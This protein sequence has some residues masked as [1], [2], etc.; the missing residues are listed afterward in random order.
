MKDCQHI[1]KL[2]YPYL[3]GELDPGQ[4]IDVE[5]HILSCQ[6]CSDLFSQE[7]RFL[8]ILK[9]GCFKEEA[10][11]SLKAKVNRLLEKEQGKKQRS[12]FPVFRNNPFRFA[13]AASLAGLLVMLFTG[14]LFDGGSEVMA[15]PPFVRA[16]VENHLQ[17]VKGKFPLEIKSNDPKIVFAWFKEKMN[18]MPDLPIIN[19]ERV[20]LLGGRITNFQ[21]DPMALVSYR[22]DNSPVTMLIIQGKAEAFVESNDHTFL[23]GRRFNFSRYKEFNT[24][25]W[26][27]DGNNFALISKFHSQNIK[28]CKVCHAK[29]SG[30]SSIDVLL[31]I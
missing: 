3:D 1:K 18:F 5:E 10:P 4:N 14:L 7:R 30:L 6:K 15:M 13:F 27:D 31:G 21:G 2:L 28:S 22:I 29:G 23:H 11:H 16:S 12:F 25:S 19:D 17:Y 9:T 26:T 20:T 24:I 8:S